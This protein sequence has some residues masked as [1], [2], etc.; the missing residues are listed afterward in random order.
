MIK[1]KINKI[2]LN[3]FFSSLT[4]VHRI[5]LMIPQ[6]SFSTV[7]IF[8]SW[9]AST[10]P[11]QK[12]MCTS[13]FMWFYVAV[14]ICLSIYLYLRGCTVLFSKTIFSCKTSPASAVTSV[15]SKWGSLTMTH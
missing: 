4:A 7:P 11:P 14:I 10:P 3:N 13:S 9:L 5:L 6:K 8:K 2:K 15:S 1:Q 12:L